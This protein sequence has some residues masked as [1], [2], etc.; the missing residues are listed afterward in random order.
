MYQKVKAYV[1]KWHMLQKEDSVIA[2]ISGGAD[3]VCLLFMLLKLQKELGFALMAVH[4]NHGIRGAEAERDEAYVKRLCRQWNV[5]L[6][7]YR[8]NVPAYAKEHGM[9][10]E[11]AGRDIRRTCFCKVLKEWGGTK[12]ALAHHE[13]DNVET[14]LWNLCRGTG[15]RGLGGI[16]PVN[17]VW[18]RPLLCV[19]RREIESYLKKRGISYCTDTTNADRRY[20]RNRIRMD[21]IPYLEDCVNTESVSHMGKTMERMYELEQYILEE[22][23]Q[24]KESCTGWKN[25][26]RIIRQTEYTKIPKALRDNVLHE[27]LCETAG[28]RKDI[29]E[30]HVQMLRDLFTKQVGKRIDLPYGV[31]AIRTYEGVRFEKNI[32]EASYAGDEN[33]L[34]S[35]RVFDREPG[36]V[37][38]PEKIYTKWFDYDIIKNTVKIRHRIAGDSIVINRYGGRKKL[39][40][41]FTDQKV[42]QEDRDKIW[43]AADGDEVLWIVG[44]RQ[45][46][47]YQITEKTTKILEIQY[48]GGEE[49]GRDN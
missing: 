47:K 4:V 41:Y 9:T 8:E 33:E 32:P 27:I 40:Q 28:R 1:K 13:N 2:G 35:I 20:M 31:T 21:V 16:A 37:T 46:Q 24:Y 7:V 44:Y 39:K 49:N 43:I 38:F 36:N 5:R 22:V 29:E 45:S 23:G 12:I 11:E 48:Y 26:R 25:G 6:K 18:I 15:I 10:E 19:K 3:S 30:V 34:F 42:P 17:D 14:L